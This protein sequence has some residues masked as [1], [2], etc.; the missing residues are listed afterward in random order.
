MISEHDPRW[1]SLK[2]GYRVPY[3]PRPALQRLRAAPND[4]KVWDDLWNNL[5]HQGDL[6]EAS[7]V[8]IVALTQ[9]RETV[10]LPS[11]QFFA[12]ASTIEVE[13]RRRTNPKPPEWLAEEYRAVW[14]EL[15][16]YALDELKTSVDPKVLQSAVAVVFLAKGLTALGALTWYHDESTLA[17]GRATDRH[18]KS[19]G[20]RSYG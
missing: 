14:G 8:A 17:E 13:R 19:V 3:D 4:A 16:E 2:G 6:G 11:D 5:H 1:A 7:Y 9:M 15:L 18:E 12:L 20:T 10:A